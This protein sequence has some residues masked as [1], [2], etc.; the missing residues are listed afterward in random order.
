MGQKATDGF[1]VGGP[2]AYNDVM[3]FV[4]PPMW[5]RLLNKAL[6]TYRKAQHKTTKAN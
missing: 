4:Y 2:P 5:K 3:E 1:V 6:S